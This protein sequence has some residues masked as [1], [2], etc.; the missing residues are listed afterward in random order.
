MVFLLQFQRR[1][2]GLEFLCQSGDLDFLDPFRRVASHPFSSG[3]A[4]PEEVKLALKFRLFPV[5]LESEF[6]MGDGDRED[7]AAMEMLFN[8]VGND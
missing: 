3:R 8:Q 1:L 4:R 6:A 2:L 7:E 5:D